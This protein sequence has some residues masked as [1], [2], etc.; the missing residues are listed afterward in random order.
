MKAEDKY[1]QRLM[2][3]KPLCLMIQAAI[4]LWGRDQAR[5]L[6][7]A[8]LNKYAHDRF[9]TPYDTVPTD[10]RWELFRNN[11][12]IHAN[13]EEYTIIEDTGNMIKLRYHRCFFLEVFRK[14]GLEDFVPLY[15]DT[16]FTTC[17][18]IHSG[19]T[20]TRTQTLADGA[21]YCDHCWRYDPGK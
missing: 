8:G 1:L 3:L 18:A 19:I 21:A 7:V 14:F 6:A 4:E 2:E 16:D 17:R 12:R 15:C 13:P 9:V 10:Q 11:I 5:E 20:M